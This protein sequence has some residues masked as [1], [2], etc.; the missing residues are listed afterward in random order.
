MRWTTTVHIAGDKKA[1]E[2]PGVNYDLQRLNP[3]DQFLLTRPYLMFPRTAPPASWSRSIQHRSPSQTFQLQN[4]RMKYLRNL[5]LHNFLLPH[6]AWTFSLISSMISI[7]FEIHTSLHVSS[8]HTFRLL[9][10]ILLY[11]Y[12]HPLDE[13]LFR[14]VWF[15]TD[16]ISMKIHE[17]I[18]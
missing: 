8:P 2:E 12:V 17:Y 11:T 10:D 9:S 6:N 18:S 4:T 7:I 3:S 13:H 16:T 1:Q 15:T 5:I 14:L